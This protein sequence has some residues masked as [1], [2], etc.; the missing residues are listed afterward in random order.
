M[1]L[2]KNAK[3]LAIAGGGND[4]GR[5][6][7]TG[8]GI[9]SEWQE[10]NALWEQLSKAGFIQGAYNGSPVEPETNSNQT[11]LNAFNQIVVLARTGD[12][13][14]IAEV[15]PLPRLHLILGRGVPVDI[16]R[17]LDIKVDDGVPDTGVL[18]L[19]IAEGAGATFGFHGESSPECITGEAGSRIYD[20]ARDSQDCNTVFLY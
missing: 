12:F 14:D 15:D 13:I 2:G 7:V 19:T 18:R 4:N 20:I 3:E 17:E 11:P 5:I 9:T 10:P 6:D 16:A 1:N 8:A